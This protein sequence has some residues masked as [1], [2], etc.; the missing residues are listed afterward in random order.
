MTCRTLECFDNIDDARTAL[1]S[2]TLE[3]F[4]SIMRMSQTFLL[5]RGYVVLHAFLK[6]D[7]GTASVVWTILFELW[8]V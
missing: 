4:M 3:T 1:V 7:D 6:S 8:Q 2:R 5:F